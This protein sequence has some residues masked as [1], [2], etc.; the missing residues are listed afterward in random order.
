VICFI[1]LFITAKTGGNAMTWHFRLGYSM[2]SLRLFRTAWRFLG[3]RWSRFTAS[4]FD[5]RS[6]VA[7]LR[8]LAPPEHSIG[9]NPLG[10]LSVYAMLFFLIAQV[11]GGLFSEDKG[12]VFGRLSL[13]VSNAT[14]RLLSG[15]HKYVGQV[16]LLLLMFVHLGA[17]TCYYF[18]Q[19]NN[20]V[21]PMIFG[22]TLLPVN[23]EPSRDDN[24][25]HMVGAIV[26]VVCAVAVGWIVRLGG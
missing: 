21:K 3:G 10:A 24:A 13:Y 25:S 8:G 22:D 11:S 14:V 9:P 1:G 23:V 5:P 4:I 16:L 18:W 19:K 12:E 2:A 7:C 20:L 6:I 26:L 15:Y 17:M